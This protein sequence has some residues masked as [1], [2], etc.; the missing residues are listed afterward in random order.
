MSQWILGLGGSDHDFSAA[1]AY[2]T[3][4]RVAIEQERVS[5]RKHS[6]LAWY[7]PPVRQAIDYCLA[8]EGISL[9][10]VSLV[11]TSDTIPARVRRDLAALPIRCFPHH[12]SHAASAYMMLPTGARAAVLVYDGFGSVCGPATGTPKRNSRETFS[13]FTFGPDGHRLLGQTR[14]EGN[15]GEDEFPIGVHDSIGMLYELVTAYLGYDVMD[16]G[17]TMGLSSHGSPRYLAELERFARR[18]DST[19]AC[20]RC[21]TDDP[22]LHAELDRILLRGGGGFAVRADLAASVQRLVN[23]TLVNCARFF[24]NEEFD[25]FCIGGGCGLNT[26]ANAHLVESGACTVPVVI[27]PHCGDA[28]LAF[29]ALWLEL[30]ARTGSRPAMTFR[31]DPLS[32]ALARPGRRYGRDEF[33]AAVQEFY[34]RLVLDAAVRSATELAGV[35]ASGHLV[36]VV[37]GGSEFGPRALGGR[38]IL[39]DPRSASTRERLNRTV[40]RREPFRPL[41]PIVLQSRYDEYFC[42]PRCADPFM[43]K[44]ARAGDRCRR[45]AP[46]VVHVDGTARVQVV[47]DYG[48]PFLVELL[49]A[50]E[51]ETGV[52]ILL[53]TSFN[54]RGEPIVETPL[55]AVDAFLGLGLD[56]LYLEGEFYR[57]AAAE[58]P[59]I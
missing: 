16:S 50:F 48:D 29:G 13:F 25:Y 39:A 38:S 19:S 34:P 7:L 44:V 1:L 8:A 2:G 37:N 5:R 57:P 47:P 43:L 20:F 41:A 58:S 35:L 49:T 51:R 12:L 28:G 15:V 18:G 59:V 42:D 52:G 23:D 21:A 11:V 33:R 46:A 14:G 3:D 36:G 54:R 30:C 22:A 24:D 17:K 9:E 4:V 27:A 6:P 10:D 56:G 55:D 53:N 40:K 45:S 31:G 26:V 32:P